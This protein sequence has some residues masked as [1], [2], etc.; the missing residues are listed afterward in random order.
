MGN[1][2]GSLPKPRHKSA[3]GLAGAE[4][5]YNFGKLTAKISL[6]CEGRGE[7]RSQFYIGFLGL[8]FKIELIFLRRFL[9]EI[10]PPRISIS[11]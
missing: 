1:S 8:S 5:K 7:R 11:T 9:F 6:K 4:Q 10:C 3:F 2:K